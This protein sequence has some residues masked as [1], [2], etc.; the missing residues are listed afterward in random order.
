MRG[1][2]STCAGAAF[3]GFLDDGDGFVVEVH[4]QTAGVTGDPQHQSFHLGS[5]PGQVLGLDPPPDQQFIVGCR[6]QSPG[7]GPAGGLVVA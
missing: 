4:A 5:V 1:Q 2:L 3:N 7:R 6:E